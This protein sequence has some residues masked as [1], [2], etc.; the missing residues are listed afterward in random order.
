M[1]WF[2]CDDKLHDHRKTRIAGKSAMGLWV[3][4]GTWSADQLTDGFIPES[5]MLRWGTRSDAAKLVKA[6]LWFADEL[7]GE[8]GWRFHDW[9]DYQPTKARREA[10][11]EARRAAGAAGGRASADTKRQASSKQNAK[12]NASSLPSKG[13]APPA[14]KRQAPGPEP[15]PVPSATDVAERGAPK[16]AAPRTRFPADFTFDDVAAET[17]QKWPR[18][19]PD[20]FDKFRDHHTAKGTTMADWRAAWRTWC[21]READFTPRGQQR[22]RT[23]DENVLDWMNLPDSAPAV[24]ASPKELGA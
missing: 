10:T 15:E 24:A 2:K 12:Q 20:V 3:I 21:G 6:G 22:R 7:D 4:A 16:R 18:I 14:S 17:A 23:R 8:Q 19:G 5:V 1:P 13:Q 9:D 11:S